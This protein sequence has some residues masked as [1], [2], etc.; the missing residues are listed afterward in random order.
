MGQFGSNNVSKFLKTNF[1]IILFTIGITVKT[2]MPKLPLVNK[3]KPAFLN[4]ENIVVGYSF[5]SQDLPSEVKND[6]NASKIINGYFLGDNNKRISVL[7]LEWQPKE[8][9]LASLAHNP[10][11]CWPN[12]GLNVINT[13]Y[14]YSKTVKISN[15]SFPFQLRVFTDSSQRINELVV[16]SFCVN[17]AW[18]ESQIIHPLNL[19]ENISSDNLLLT[20]IIKNFN[21][22]I[23]W[24]CNSVQLLMRQNDYHNSKRQFVRLSLELKDFD[25][26]VDQLEMFASRWLA[27]SDE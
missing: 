25:N 8:G 13:G 18:G 26:S 3:T 6:L 23:E 21:A 19:D 24:F 5:K 7:F 20:R 11:I 14:D 12:Q 16:W 9:D 1:G 22:R 27:V 15:Y 17:G 10:D 2:W 4:P